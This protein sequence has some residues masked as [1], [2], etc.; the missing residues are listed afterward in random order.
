M[1]Y[2]VCSKCD[3][4]LRCVKNEKVVRFGGA[5]IKWGDEYQCP[6]CGIKVITGFGQAVMPGHPDYNVF[7]TEVE[8]EASYH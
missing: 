2:M 6:R 4:T 7:E 1:S 3:V 8:V 5:E